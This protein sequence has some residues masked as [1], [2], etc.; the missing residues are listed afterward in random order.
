MIGALLFFAI[1]ATR[2]SLGQSP[3][4][5]ADETPRQRLLPPPRAIGNEPETQAKLLSRLRDFLKSDP[6]KGAKLPALSDDEVQSL[7]QAMKQYGGDL[8][9]G[10]SPDILD[11][12]PPEMISKALSNPELMRQAK[13]IAEQFRKEN[14]PRQNAS[15]TQAGDPSLP[16]PT[17]NT[18]LPPDSPTRQ[19]DNNSRRTP[20]SNNNRA[21]QTPVPT[22]EPKSN[23][24]DRPAQ[25]NRSAPVPKSKPEGGDFKELMNK[26]LKTQQQFEQSKNESQDSLPPKDSDKDQS[27]FDNPFEERQPDRLTTTKET[28]VAAGTTPQNK[29]NPA[30]TPSQSGSQNGS[31]RSG[32]PGGTSSNRATPPPASQPANS[33]TPIAQTPGRNRSTLPRS[34][35]KEESA[36]NGAQQ[37]R[38]QQSSSSSSSASSANGQNSNATNATNNGT[39]GGRAN[40]SNSPG[41]QDIRK[42]LDR[43]GFG[44][45]FQKIIEDARAKVA[46]RPKPNGTQP[47]E[48]L[49]SSPKIP[50]ENKGNS[51]ANDPANRPANSPNPPSSFKA[52]DTAFKPA[53]PRPSQP[54]SDFAKGVKQASN[55]LNSLW[56]QIAKTSDGGAP[57]T[58]TPAASSQNSLSI[59]AIEM[60]NPLDASVLPYIILI[61][62]LGAIAVIALRYRVQAEQA[63]KEMLQAQL[64]PVV[65]DI[66]TR[67]DLVLA[68]HALA[69]RRFKAAQAWWTCGYVTQQFESKLPQH[70]NPMHTLSRLYDQAR[71]Y[72]MEHQLTAKQIDEAKLALKQCEG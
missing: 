5:P 23:P 45:A 70:K 58:S 38:S 66:R 62:S 31:S 69:K 36:T 18:N 60:P 8:P 63:R 37:N 32:S 1:C 39:N 21:E 9:D 56:T 25:G 42:E 26:L 19:R 24:N 3:A 22:A 30:L 35:P 46:Q 67:E 61:V 4:N 53:A 13:E 44:P 6:A 43:K 40:P 10:L 14:G 48:S 41:S 50:A 16:K 57:S 2:F 29:S 47:A 27:P 7:K 52:T 11:S 71:Y 54:D 28:E 68:F 17:E 72:P 12:I 59:E 51:A 34:Q 64:A 55:Y 33:Q 65:D 15:P 49:P 20:G